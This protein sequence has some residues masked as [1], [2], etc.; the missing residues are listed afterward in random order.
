[1]TIKIFFEN[2]SDVDKVAKRLEIKK[3]AD[4]LVVESKEI[5]KNALEKEKVRGTTY[6]IA[7]V[8]K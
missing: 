8:E 6:S 1:M 4:C 3:D 2:I 5:A 7:E